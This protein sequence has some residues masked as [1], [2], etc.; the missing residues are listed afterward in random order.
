[1]HFFHDAFFNVV[2]AVLFLEFAYCFG[3]VSPCQPSQPRACGVSRVGVGSTIEQLNEAY[4][5][6]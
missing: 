3:F 2:S 5:L 1:M 6:V 4:Y